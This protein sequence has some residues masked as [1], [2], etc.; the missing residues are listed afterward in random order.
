[1]KL[2]NIKQVNELISAVDECKGDVFL[3]S[4]FGDKFNLKSK[5]SQY[6]AIAALIGENSEDLELWCTDKEDEYKM[7]KFLDEHSE[8]LE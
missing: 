7:L 5:L 4:E 2:K 8:I 6:V 3:T 1:M